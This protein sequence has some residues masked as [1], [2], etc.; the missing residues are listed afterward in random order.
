MN[1]YRNVDSREVQFDFV[2]SSAIPERYDEEI[3]FGGGK[4][5]RLPS[6]S[7]KPLQYCGELYR[8]IQSNGYTVVHIHKN[9]ASMCMDAFAAKLAGAKTVIGHS[10][11][12]S[13]NIL[14]QHKLLK[15]FVNLFCDERFACS[16]EAGEWVFGK[17][18]DVRIINNAIDVEKFAFDEQL[19]EE[20][21]NALG[22]S[23]KYVIGFVGRLHMQ[24]NPYRLLEIFAAAHEINSDAILLMVGDGEERSGLEKKARELGLE[25]AVLFLG[26]RSDV[27][28]L[29]MAMD[30][31][32]MT[33]FFEGMPVVA[34][35][36]QATGLKTIVSEN[37][38]APDLIRQQKVLNLSNSN[39]TW[40]REILEKA[41][42]DRS[43]GAKLVDDGGY[44][45][46]TQ[47]RKLQE[48]YLSCVQ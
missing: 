45:I 18:S 42:F 8:V 35:E 47:A 24:K 40:A 11:N 26:S 29:M 21:R 44:G 23:G 32:V 36:A 15:P 16:K 13:C 17:R 9:S 48:F 31:F 12:T 27:P 10:H 39:D 14:W 41:D 20:Y 2:T 19:R 3:L 34:V 38:P 4:I 1:Y 5:Y 22:I 7:R 46:K 25:D 43:L 6:R 33:S 28:Q 37:V 30:V